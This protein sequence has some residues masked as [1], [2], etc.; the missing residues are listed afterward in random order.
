MSKK[1]KFQNFKSFEIGLVSLYADF[2]MV[3][4]FYFKNGKST[5]KETYICSET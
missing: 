2:T 3:N 5:T 1:M 4:P